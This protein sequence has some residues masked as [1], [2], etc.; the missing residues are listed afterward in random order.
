MFFKWFFIVKNHFKRFYLNKIPSFK[1][2]SSLEMSLGR[3]TFNLVLNTISNDWSCPGSVCEFKF[4]M[5]RNLLLFN[6]ENVL[7]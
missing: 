6:K 1:V 4:E 5:R 7:W 2:F 3:D